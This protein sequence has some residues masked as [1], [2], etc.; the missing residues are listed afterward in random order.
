[1]RK[2]FSQLSERLQRQ[3]KKLSGIYTDTCCKWAGKLDSAFRDVPVK[4]DIFYAVQRL[5]S[6][7]PKRTNFHAEIVRAYSL[8]FRDP[9]NLGERRTLKTPRLEVLIDNLK[10]FEREWKDVKGSNGHAVLNSKATKEIK[11]IKAHIQEGLPIRHSPWVWHERFNKHLNEFLSTDKIGTSLAYA[12]CVKLFAQL[13]NMKENSTN[14]FADF[15]ANATSQS[16]DQITMETFGIEEESVSIT[17]NLI[18][19]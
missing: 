3:G 16:L 13:P 4:L 14:F 1:M 6:T 7:I 5:S 11:N 12:R 2:T 15:D 19:R 17:K 9:R 8:V 10:K 18:E